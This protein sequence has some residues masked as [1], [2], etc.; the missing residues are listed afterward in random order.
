MEKRGNVYYELE[1]LGSKEQRGIDC[2]TMK[3]SVLCDVAPYNLVG[4]PT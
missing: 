2:V 1:T 4:W 3:T